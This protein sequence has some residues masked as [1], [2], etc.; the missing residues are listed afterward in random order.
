MVT[1][2]A[3]RRA[4]V[5]WAA[6]TAAVSLLAV[7]LLG[8]AAVPAA[9]AGG[10]LLVS[11]DGV[12]FTPDSTLPLFDRMG[13]VVP[14]DQSTEQLWVKNDSTADAVLRI[15]LVGPRTDSPALAAAFSL[16]TRQPGRPASAPVTIET[17][18]RNGHCTVLA[19]G[20]V[21]RPGQHL[22]LRLTAAVDPALDERHGVLG[23]VRFRLRGLLTEATAARPARPGS[24]CQEPPSPGD[25]VAPGPDHLPSTGSGALLP[26]GL[27]GV[28][29]IVAG[30]VI[31]ILAWRR[32]TPDAAGESTGQCAR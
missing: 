4:T 15:D 19:D 29:A 9:A 1:S 22:R 31:G 20:V 13:R 16:N 18:V 26:V 24:V 14:G 10:Q 5:A 32:R 21:L 12:Q 11:R 25:P 23:T 8:G 17:G 6:P 27:V 7:A 30:T 2:S 28:A 3:M